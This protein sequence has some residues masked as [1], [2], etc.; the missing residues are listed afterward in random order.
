MLR[1]LLSIVVPVGLFHFLLPEAIFSQG[2]TTSE[3]VGQVRDPAHAAV[4][5]ATVAIRNQETGLKRIA[6][7]DETG[8]STSPS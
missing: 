7:S 4:P 6:K 2:E 5:G 8:S 1:S 3:I